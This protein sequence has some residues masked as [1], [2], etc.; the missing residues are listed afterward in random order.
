MRFPETRTMSAWFALI[1]C[2]T[3]ICPAALSVGSQFEW[4]ERAALPLPR[5]GYMGGVIRGRL[6]I[7][8]GS[9]WENR[10]QK[11]WTDRV[12]A[13]DPRANVWLP[14]APLPEPRSD[15]ASVVVGNRLYLFGGGAGTTI[16]KDALVYS[17]GSWRRLPEGDL[18]A[19]RMYPVAVAIADSIYLIGGLARAND[20]SSASASLWRWNLHLPTAGWEEMPPMPGPPRVAGAVAVLRHRIYVFAGAKGETANAVRNLD[21][22]YEF[23]TQTKEWKQLPRLPFVAEAWWPVLLGDRILLLGGLRGEENELVSDIYEFQPTSGTLRQV[24][25]LPHAV[26]DTK[27]FVIKNQVIGTGGEAGPG[28]RAP[29]TMQTRV[30]PSAFKR[31]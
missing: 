6:V 12:D 26:A 7:A 27:F 16:R 1:V 25:N 17:D 28:F 23:D 3:I 31:K 2:L 5:A 18:P 13:F 9:Y 30:P 11:K 10:K 8:G 21:D 15:A 24:G 29:W 4:R 22:A 20:Y 19:P 14:L